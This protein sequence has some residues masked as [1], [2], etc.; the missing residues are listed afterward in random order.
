[1]INDTTTVS[2]TTDAIENQRFDVS[3]IERPGFVR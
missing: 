1:V 3:E 2:S